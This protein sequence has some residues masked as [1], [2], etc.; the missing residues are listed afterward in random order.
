ML[1]SAAGVDW[2]VVGTEV[3]SLQ[4]EY[5][6]IKEF[7]PQVQ[8]PLPGRQELPLPGGHA[9][10]GVPAGHGDARRPAA[11]D[12]LLRPV[13]ARLGH[14]GDR[15]HAAA[16]VPGPDLLGRGV[17]AGRA[18]RQAVPAR[19]HRQVLGAVRGADQRGRAPAAWPR[20]SATSWPGR[21]PGS[22]RGSKRRC[23]AAAQAEEYRAGRAAAGR[24]PGTGAGAG[25]AGRGARRR[26]R[27]RRDRAGRG[28]ARG[29]GAGVLR[30]R[31][32]GSRPARLG[33]GQGRGRQRGELVEQF[34]G[35]VYGE[36][37][38]A[39]NGQAPARL[40]GTGDAGPAPVPPARG[41]IP[42]EVLVPVLPPAAAAVEEWLCRP[43]REPG[44]ACGYRAA[45]TRRR[46][47]TPWHATRRSRWR[48][49]RCAGPA[50]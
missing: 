11:R 38:V 18:D 40:A 27:L 29:R 37:A 9:G 25:A 23:A 48:S 19:L 16:G 20:S 41:S 7:E 1:T 24:H 26:H 21:R 50:T 47:S 14:Q 3:E 22:P 43:P 35:Q 44:A 49:T 17:Q 31:R 8:R 28:S 10:R 36:D 2:T 6:W 4:L 13:L 46:C 34:L 42:R 33:G 5:S 12:P 39:G 32:P 15:G 30:P 45:A